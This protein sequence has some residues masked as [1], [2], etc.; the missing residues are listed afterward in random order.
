MFFIIAFYTMIL[1]F[2]Y[3]KLDFLEKKKESMKEPI[4]ARIHYLNWL[5]MRG[6]YKVDYENEISELYSEMEILQRD[7]DD[8]KFKD[9][10][11]KVN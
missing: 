7:F 1:L 11:I 9:V 3:K 2:Y 5:I 6:D 8:F 4:K 10:K